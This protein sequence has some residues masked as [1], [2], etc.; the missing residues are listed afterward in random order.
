LKFTL[1]FLVCVASAQE[2]RDVVSFSRHGDRFLFQ[3][4]EGTAELEWSTASTF[5]FRRTFG[6]ELP[7]RGSREAEPVPVAVKQ[8]ADAITFTTT[9]LSATVRLEDLRIGVQKLDGTRLLNDLTAAQRKDGVISW[10]REASPGARYYGL[11]ART[12]SSLNLRGALVRNATPFLISTAG[13]GEQHVAPARYDFDLERLRRGRYRVDVRGS[14]VIDYYFYFGPTPKEIFEERLKVLGATFTAGSGS[15]RWMLEQSLTGIILPAET[16]TRIVPAELRKRL[17][18]YLR[19]YIQEVHDRG[20]PILHPLPVQ[21]PRDPEADKYPD[22][23]MLGDE[24]LVAAGRSVYLPQG[25]W[26]NLKTNEVTRGRQAVQIAEVPS[27]F[28]RNGSIVPLAGEGTLELHYFPKLGAEFFLYEED[29]GD[30]T[31]AHAAPAADIMRLEIESKVGRDYTWVV[32]HLESV[33]SV[34]VGEMEF[35]AVK[36][37]AG[38]SARTWYY[39][40]AR[41][42]LY[43]RDRVTAGQDHILNLFF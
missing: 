24:L 20:C 28:A 31:Q 38:L 27:L 32:H 33:K 39:D 42:N 13:Y 3:L 17:D 7:A 23:A 37:T 41:Q 34:V 22:E 30:Y 6:I 18:A 12:G 16:V 29:A 2:R 5:R 21:F 8:S 4:R 26:T 10:E 35:A 19:A 15:L 40:E 11:G 43:V 9:F 1:L 36:S 25:I 14:D